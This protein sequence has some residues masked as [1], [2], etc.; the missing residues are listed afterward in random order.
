[1]EFPG[2]ADFHADETVLSKDP[3]KDVVVVAGVGNV[4]GNQLELGAR[5]LHMAGKGLLLVTPSLH[6]RCSRQHGLL[7]ASA[8]SAAH[9]SLL[10]PTGVSARAEPVAQFPESLF[11]I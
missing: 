11:N 7:A 9:V 6:E 4:P 10:A 3:I 5:L 8:W 2:R 1:L